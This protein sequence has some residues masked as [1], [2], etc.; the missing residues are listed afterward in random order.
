[1]TD[2]PYEAE[3]HTKQRRVRRGP[4]NLNA[5]VE[6][7]TF[8]PVTSES[9]IEFGQEFAR[10]SKRWALVFCQ[11][12][13][14]VM[15][16]DAMVPMSYRRTCIWVKPDGMPQ[17]TGDRPGMGYETIVAMHAP[18]R[19][20]W[21]A[22]GKVGVYTHNKRNDM[23]GLHPTMKPVELMLDLVCD[24]TNPD[25]VI[26]DAFAGSGT[27]GVA[28]L[29]LGRRA[30]LIEQNEEFAQIARE[31]MLAEERW[32][33]REELLAKQERLFAAP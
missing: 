10:V 13:A 29:R 21:N 4:G 9:R 7:L 28:A 5:V 2:P 12:E 11:C 15:W 18:G 31:R 26:L 17:L 6:P 33:T 1:V 32:Q 3:A 14:S 24:F 30:I 23:P 27:T 19:S 20:K 16:R 25:D 8:E 22:V